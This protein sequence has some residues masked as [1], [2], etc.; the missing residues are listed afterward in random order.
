M[1]WKLVF[2]I[3]W[4]ALSAAYSAGTKGRDPVEVW[5]LGVGVFLMIGQWLTDME[6]KKI[7]EA[8]K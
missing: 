3:S 4:V 6:I 1:T 5:V 2:G 7:L 8:K